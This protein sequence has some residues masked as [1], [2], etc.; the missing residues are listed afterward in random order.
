MDFKVLGEKIKKRRIEKSLSEE[1]LGKC[2]R[3]PKEYVER[4]EN[5]EP[6]LTIKQL[7]KI[8]TRLDI[9]IEEILDIEPVE[10]KSE[11]KLTQEIFDIFKK[12]SPKDKQTFYKLVEVISMTKE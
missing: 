4:F 8:C 1:E 10:L 7:D 9:T 12:L 3:K 11:D 2:I 6:I 5:G